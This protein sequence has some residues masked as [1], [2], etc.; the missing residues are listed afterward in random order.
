M[1]AYAEI[2]ALVQ[3]L[4]TERAKL[5]AAVGRLPSNDLIRPFD[6]GWSGKDILAHLA[7][8]E[9]L[10][11]KF[12]KLMVSHESPVQLE[13]FAADYPDFTG[14]FSL[15]GF[16]AYLAEK[17]GSRSLAEVLRRLEETRTDTLAWVET[18]TPDQLGRRGQHAVWGD[19][20]VRGLLR[21]LALHDRVHTNEI[22][23]AVN[24]VGG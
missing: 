14:Q 17:L 8:A 13:A 12:G 5:W 3:K 24:R 19:Q 6:G 22:S 1:S 15:D 2:E 4:R 16:N 10:N 7:A 23:K 11:V 18:L 21:I 20:T 9:E